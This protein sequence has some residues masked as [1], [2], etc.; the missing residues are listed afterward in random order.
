[1]KT[2]KQISSFRLFVIGLVILAGSI[3][4]SCDP[5]DDD[6]TDGTSGATS[7]NIKTPQLLKNNTILICENINSHFV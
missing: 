4:N 6:T 1:M 2:A 3:C 5:N 7:L